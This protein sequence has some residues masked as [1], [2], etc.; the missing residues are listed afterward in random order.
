MTF[1][2]DGS[3]TYGDLPARKPGRRKAKVPARDPQKA[4]AYKLMRAETGCEVCGWSLGVD[5]WEALHAHHVVPLSS[6]GPDSWDNMIALCPNHHTIAHRTGKRD[7]WRWT[8][9]RS[10]GELLAVLRPA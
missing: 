2:Y 3:V 8:G 5:E 4:K 6:G 10:K 7:Y 9:P 1:A